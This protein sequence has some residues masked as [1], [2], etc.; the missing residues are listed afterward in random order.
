MAGLDVEAACGEDDAP[1]ASPSRHPRPP[2]E[3]AAG[4]PPGRPSGARPM[5]PGSRAKAVPRPLVTGS[6]S[7]SHVRSPIFFAFIARE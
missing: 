4:P 6:L 7:A 5:L 1:R 2:D 3:V